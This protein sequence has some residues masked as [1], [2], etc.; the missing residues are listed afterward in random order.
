LAFRA[1]V[2][3]KKKKTSDANTKLPKNRAEKAKEVE[4]EA[5][6]VRIGGDPLILS[7]VKMNLGFKNDSEGPTAVSRRLSEAMGRDVHFSDMNLAPVPRDGV[8]PMLQIFN[9]ADLTVEDIDLAKQ[10]M[11]WDVWYKHYP[12]IEC[13]KRVHGSKSNSDDLK[14]EKEFE[15]RAKN[16]SVEVTQFNLRMSGKTAAPRTR[17]GGKDKKESGNKTLLR[18]LRKNRAAAKKKKEQDEDYR[19]DQKIITAVR[20]LLRE[21]RLDGGF[22]D[23]VDKE[24]TRV[25]ASQIENDSEECTAEQAH[26]ILHELKLL[27]N[28]QPEG[29]KD[30]KKKG[31]SPKADE[32]GSEEGSGSEDS[33]FDEDILFK[34]GE[35]TVFEEALKELIHSK[36]LVENQGSD[37]ENA[38]G[39]PTCSLSYKE[40]CDILADDGE[41]TEEIKVNRAAAKRAESMQEALA[42]DKPWEKETPQFGELI[43]K[44]F[45]KQKAFNDDLESDMEQ[46]AAHRKVIPK[47]HERTWDMGL[48]DHTKESLDHACIDLTLNMK[49]QFQVKANKPGWMH[50]RLY[51]SDKKSPRMKKEGPLENLRI[52]ANLKAHKSRLKT[53]KAGGVPELE[54]YAVGLG[55]KSRQKTSV[56]KSI[57]KRPETAPAKHLKRRLPRFEAIMKPK[58]SDPE[59]TDYELVENSRETKKFIVDDLRGLRM[60]ADNFK[61]ESAR[62]NTKRE[63]P[64]H[65]MSLFYEN[66]EPI[67][68]TSNVMIDGERFEYSDAFTEA[69]KVAAGVKSEVRALGAGNI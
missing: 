60:K 23:D 42:K 47:H 51:V 40:Y 18:L 25:P 19:E 1:P 52:V 55:G 11:K 38:T 10:E 15:R 44:M 21:G 4:K 59:R 33:D 22:I 16:L 13:Q 45:V 27:A 65:K 62:F 29:K 43:K 8:F 12:R 57:T 36:K 41:D 32:D 20:A 26:Q 39:L 30:G 2:L 48:A 50:N 69:M 6:M 68:A 66:R 14:I 34:E 64:M 37:I 54:G 17:I 61:R 46:K 58:P 56:F 28:K 3:T 24:W 49:V 9:G 7:S 63:D 53:I 67:H 35:L 5:P 31:G